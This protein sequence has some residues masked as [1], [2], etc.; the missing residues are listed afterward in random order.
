MCYEIGTREEPGT[1][2]QGAP[3]SS[4]PGS[5]LTFSF[6]DRTQNSRVAGARP[7]HQPIGDSEPTK[8]QGCGVD[9]LDTKQTQRKHRLVANN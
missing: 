3:V 1:L 4:F 8:G 5:S 7:N 6:G 2:T 9:E